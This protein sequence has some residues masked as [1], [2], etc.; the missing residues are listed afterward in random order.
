ML[1]TNRINTA[2][3]EFGRDAKS[4]YD[5]TVAALVALAWKYPKSEGDFAWDTEPELYAEALRLCR[6]LTDNCLKDVRRVIAGVIGD[7]LDYADEEI[8]YESA[9]NGRDYL[10]RFD[11]AG[12]H[13]LEL[14]AVWI[15]LGLQK[16]YTASYIRIVASRYANYPFL[17]PLWREAGKS[18]GWGRGYGFNIYS[19]LQRIGWDLI[20]DA[21]RY[22]EWVDAQA[23]GAL[24]FIMRRGSSFD[25][26]TCDEM[27]NHKIPITV[28]I[29]RPHPNCM[30][31]PEY[32]FEED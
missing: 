1:S 14:L 5:Q 8:A 2:K 20:I 9:V 22:A 15:T 11:M 3:Q 29:D 26:P 19:R 25:C 23:Q 6:E 12:S 7:S 4:R 30:C 32:H 13:L 18:L 27:C 16:D 28:P 17:N 10:A 21:V 31:W 24:Y